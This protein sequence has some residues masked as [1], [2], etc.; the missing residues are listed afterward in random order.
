[1][2]ES[3]GDERGVDH[4]GVV[5]VDHRELLL[6]DPTANGKRQVGGVEEGDRASTDGTGAS[7]GDDDRGRR[8]VV[9]GDFENRAVLL[10]DQHR[11][12]IFVDG[13]ERIHARGRGYLSA[14][15]SGHKASL[16]AEK[17]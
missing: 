3:A 8:E 17:M 13:E 1:M 15:R 14:G 2:T 7:F 12:P 16:E 4:V 5:G 10:R 9:D 11:V 6:A